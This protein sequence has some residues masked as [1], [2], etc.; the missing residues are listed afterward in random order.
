MQI[1]KISEL[2]G[3]RRKA[4]RHYEASGLIP[5]PCRV[6]KYRI[7]TDLDV[8]LISIIKRAQSVGFSLAELNQLTAH[9]AQQSSF[10]LDMANDLIDRKR[11]ALQAE[12]RRIANQDKNLQTLQEALNR[13]FSSSTI[14]MDADDH[15]EKLLTLPLG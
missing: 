3:A 15:C 4:I 7:Y 8:A 1:G 13:I 9:K 5:I 11:L 14:S 2:T 12:T 10:P 6:G